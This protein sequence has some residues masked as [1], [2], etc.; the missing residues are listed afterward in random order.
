MITD[1]IYTSVDFS[2]LYFDLR[3]NEGRI[4]SDQEVLCLPDIEEKHPYF[5]EWLIRKKSCHQLLKYLSNQKKFLEILEVGCGNGWLS[6]KLSALP[7]AH[8]TG[9]DISTEELKQAQRVFDRIN[10]LEFINC[11][12][13]DEMLVNRSFDIIV[14]AASLQYFASLKHV[15]QASLNHLKPGGEIHILDTHFYKQ[16]EL[17]AARQRSRDYFQ[18]IGF[19][20]M[21][22]HYFHH[23]FEELKLFNNKKLYNPRS[24]ANKLKNN[25]N[26]FYWVC[27]T[28]HA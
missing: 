3:Q 18:S 10:N 23:S 19:P 26:P 14:F 27:I 5:R 8:V 28:N 13:Q 4:Y 2:Q 21:E 22:N 16:K 6:A 7:S 25:S 24:V 17:T 1:S 11:A 12:L 20:E 15:L 9:I